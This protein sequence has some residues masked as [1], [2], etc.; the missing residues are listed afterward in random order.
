MIKF[1]RELS[2]LNI[3]GLELYKNRVK[4]ILTLL[5]ALNSFNTSDNDNTVYLLI[6]KYE[7]LLST[8][9]AVLVEKNKFDE[10]RSKYFDTVMKRRQTKR[11]SGE[12][13]TNS[14][15]SSSPV[16]C[17]HDQKH[18]N[19][20]A[21]F[22][23]LK[24]LGQRISAFSNA[25]AIIPMEAST[26]GKRVVSLRFKRHSM[27]TFLE[28]EAP[29]I[30]VANV[31]TEKTKIEEQPEED[32]LNLPET[33]EEFILEEYERLCASLKAE[34]RKVQVL[35]TFLASLRLF[36]TGLASLFGSLIVYYL[37]KANSTGSDDI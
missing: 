28:N 4:N 17:E 5:D 37:E 26:S 14:S 33:L 34:E 24:P 1:L 12:N 3:F 36:L 20:V 25:S 23:V 35:E 32:S 22:P 11:L 10:V 16:Q 6:C 8:V 18:V 19:N 15:G 29:H 31:N 7:I 9:D 13:S 30:G 2:C 27:L 21:E